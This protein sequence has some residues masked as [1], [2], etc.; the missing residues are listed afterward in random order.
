MHDNEIKELLLWHGHR[1]L[2]I[3]VG[4]ENAPQ[5]FALVCLI[6]QCTV[7]L[8]KR[9]YVR[10][11]FCLCVLTKGSSSKIQPPNN[12]NVRNCGR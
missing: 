1:L 2:W 5:V 8:S 3:D 9:Q 11:L 6:P 7:L 4:E 12:A 10:N